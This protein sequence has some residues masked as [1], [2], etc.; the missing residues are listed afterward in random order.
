VL[1][2][3]E[4]G[5]V[6]GEF[7]AQRQR[8]GVLQVGAADLDDVGKRLALAC[9]LARSWAAPAAR[10]WPAP[11]GGHVD[12]GREDVVGRLA[13][14]DV[15]VRV[16]QALA[17]HAAHQLGAA[18]GQHFV[19]VHVG[20]GAGAGLPHGQREFAGML[21]GQHFVGGLGDGD[22]LGAVQQAEVEVDAGG[23]ALDA[24]QRVDQLGR[25]FFGG[26]AEMFEE[27][28]VCAPHSWASGTSIGPKLS[29]SLR[30]F[31]GDPWSG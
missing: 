6:A 26:D 17:A 11:G 18:V 7:L 25:H 14:V 5:D 21:A 10:C 1:G 30:V 19:H 4:V 13:F 15:V 16:Q 28:W 9:R 24:G 2:K 12:G 22:G 3:V 20:L 31:M 23:G 29:R 27:R 8:R